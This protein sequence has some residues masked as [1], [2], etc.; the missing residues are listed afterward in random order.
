MILRQY[1]I[2]YKGKSKDVIQQSQDN[3][4]TREGLRAV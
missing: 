3:L 1:T 4:E 2:K